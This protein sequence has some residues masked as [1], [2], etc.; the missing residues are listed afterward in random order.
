MAF[1]KEQLEEDM[2]DFDYFGLARLQ[3]GVSPAQANAEINAMQHTIVARLPANEKATLSAT[4]TPFQQVLVGN[5]RKPLLILLAAVVGLMLV[6]CVNIAN[7]LLARAVGKRQQMAVAA[8]LGASRRE[9]L[10]LA[11][12]E[13]VVLAVVGGG[14]GILLATIMMPA[15]Q[16]YLPSALDFRGPL[17]LDWAGAF[18]A[19]VLAVVATLLA[20][21]S[22]AWMMARTPP[23]EV[24]HSESRLATESRSS[25]RMRRMLVGVEV[26]VSVALVLMTGLLTTSLYRLL[27]VDRGFDVSR[28]VT[29]TIDLPKK[30]YSGSETRNPFYKQVLERLSQ[31]PGVEYAA[32]ASEVPLSGDRWLDMIKVPGDTRP[33]MQLPSEHFRWVSPGYFET[34][35]LPLVAGRLLSLV[36][37]GKHDAVVSE[38][39][40]KTL[41]PGKNPIGQQFGRA[42]MDEGPFTVIGVVGNA[43]TVSLSQPDPMMVYVPY[44]YRSETTGGLVVRTRQD[45][46]AMADAMRKAVWS[47]DPEV[48]VEE[49]RLLGGV[50]EDSVANRRFEMQLL[51]LFASS[52][53]LLAALGVYGVVTYSVVQR[54]KEIGLRVAL[55]A[56]RSNIYGLV[57][58]DGLIPVL[59]GAVAGVAVA[60]ASARV[61]SSLLFQVSPYDSAIAVSAVFVLVA[62]GTAACLLPARR[63][64][65]VD[66]MQA[67][68]RE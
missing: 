7:L 45:P 20:G 63:A 37:E 58:Q 44:W 9:M 8:A 22:P 48:P 21:A 2:G 1:S 61:M 49:I 27:H 25:K 10:R 42:G 38:L 62:M 11:M 52:A 33:I 43:R 14:L 54:E 26:M 28:I 18:C 40:A 39:T 15:M 34:I 13:T 66:P 41:W 23:Q 19:V 57:L 36:D 32:A 5:N 51:L 31:L 50:V 56:Q 64:A 16:R 60:F 29:A 55:G 46:A 24:L 12:R 6:G 35:R 3:P 68:R 59:A 53:L 67:L 65:A 30:S 17:H 47:V 4:V